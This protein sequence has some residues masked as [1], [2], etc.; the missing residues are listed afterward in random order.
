MRQTKFT[1]MKIALHLKTIAS[2]II[3]QPFAK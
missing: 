1:I 2:I 3:S